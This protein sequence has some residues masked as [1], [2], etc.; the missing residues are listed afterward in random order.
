MRKKEATRLQ[1]LVLPYLSTE[2]LKFDTGVLFKL[3]DKNCFTITLLVQDMVWTKSSIKHR[4]NFC[5]YDNIFKNWKQ[6]HIP[7]RTSVT[8]FV[9]SS[10]LRAC[11]FV[12]DK[13]CSFDW[14]EF[15]RMAWDWL[16]LQSWRKERHLEQILKLASS[17]FK[18]YASS[19]HS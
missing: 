7:F 8:L 19:S 16:G 4:I 11:R 2:L 1:L 10:T 18:T 12:F 15:L 6:I 17:L 5:I 9:A 14:L 13:I 3:W